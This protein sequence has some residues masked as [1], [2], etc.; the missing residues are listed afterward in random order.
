MKRRDFVKASCTLT[1]GSLAACASPIVHVAAKQQGGRLVVSKAVFATQSLV[2]VAAEPFP[3][4]I[5]KVS[6]D[7]YVATK[8]ECTHQSCQTVLVENGYV[9]PCHG[10]RFA[11]DGALQKGPALRDLERIPVEVEETQI[12]LPID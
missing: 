7:E 11:A 10:S 8:M 12:S 3:I 6:S 1:A 9:C 4:G 5:A 2:T